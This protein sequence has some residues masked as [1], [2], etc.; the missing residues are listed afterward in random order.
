MTHQ[1]LV[2]PVAQKNGAT[3]YVAVEL[4]MSGLSLRR[5]ANTSRSR[6]CSFRCGSPCGDARGSSRALRYARS[7]RF[8]KSEII[9]SGRLNK[10]NNIHH[11]TSNA[12]SSIG[13]IQ[14]TC[15]S[16]T[17][18]ITLARNSGIR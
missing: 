15:A 5:Q 14:A 4:S 12:A 7:R 10:V 9:P 16:A 1:A 18:R 8:R 3:I 2:V 17:G 11:Y 13:K 6:V